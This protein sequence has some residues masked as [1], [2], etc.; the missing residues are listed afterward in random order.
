M[1]L[2]VA[3]RGTEIANTRAG[4]SGRGPQGRVRGFE[5]KS[6][7]TRILIF[8]EEIQSYQAS[9]V[10][11]HVRGRTRSALVFICMAHENKVLCSVLPRIIFRCYYAVVVCGVW[12]TRSRSGSIVTFFVY[13]PPISRPLGSLTPTLRL[14]SPGGSLTRLRAT[15]GPPW[16]APQAECRSLT[17]VSPSH[18]PIAPGHATARALAQPTAGPGQRLPPCMCS[19]GM[20]GNLLSTSPERARAI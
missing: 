10:D 8:S 19:G 15:P 2:V 18:R 6:D 13:R 7:A 4:G 5:R 20:S 1:V 14:P 16:E 11:V 12:C 17:G 3:R 9:N